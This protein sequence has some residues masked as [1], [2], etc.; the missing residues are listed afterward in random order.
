MSGIYALQF[1][2]PLAAKGSALFRRIKAL[3]IKSKLEERT[4]ASIYLV[5]FVVLA[6]ILFAF[7]SYR[8]EMPI[9]Q[10]IT[11]T[12]NQKETIEDAAVFNM[13]EESPELVGGI[14][15]LQP[16]LKYPDEAKRKGVEG[17]VMIQF[18]VDE[19]GRVLEPKVIRGIGSGCDQAA[20]EAV[21][22]L[23]FIA[24]KQSGKKVKVRYT[25]PVAFKL[26]Q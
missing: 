17:K 8:I 18:I 19:A 23:R 3:S 20:L 24:G 25:L 7:N 2:T 21:K 5:F 6:P 15:S 1:A 4:K 16:H 14:A 10:E 12:H 9:D 13:V 11:I 26:N 22:N